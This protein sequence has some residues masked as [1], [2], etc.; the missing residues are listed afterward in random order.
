VILS[1]TASDGTAGLRAIK[2]ENGITIA[3]DPASAKF[4][5]MPRNAIAA[6]CVDLVLPP[7]RIAAELVRIAHHPF[8]AMLP[9][10]GVEAL[11]AK[12]EDWPRLFRLLRTA[13]TDFSLYKKSMIARRLGRRMAVHKIESLTEYLK[14]LEENSAELDILFQDI[15]IHVTSFFRDPEVFTALRD[16]IFPKILADRGPGEPVRIWV[17]G[18]STGEEVYSIAICLLEYLGDRSST[19]R[20]QIFASDINELALERARAGIYPEEQ[21]EGVSEERR[22]RFFTRVNGNYVVNQNIRELCVFARHDLTRDPPFS[23][24]DLL[25]CRNVLIYFEPTLQKRVLVSFHYALRPTGLLML[26]KTESI[27]T[28]ANLFAATDR[29]HKVLTRSP[30]PGEPLELAHATFERLAPY[31]RAKTE[32]PPYLDLEKEADRLVWERYAHAGIIVNNELQILHFRGQTAP[33]L[34]PVPGRASLNL[35]KM[36]REDLQM[37]LRAAFREARK[38]GGRVRREGIQ[39]THDQQLRLVNIEVCPLPGSTGAGRCFLVLIDDITPGGEQA[40]RPVPRRRGKRVFGEEVVRLEKELERMREHLQTVIHEQEYTNEELKTAN[41]EALSSMEELQSTN[42]EL[43]TAKEE[44]QS[45]NEE[46]VTLNE[47]L[48]NRNLELTHLSDDL[49]NVI[50]GV[51][52]PIVILDGERRIRRFTPPAE[53]LLGILPADVGRPIENLRIGVNVPDFKDLLSSILAKAGEVGREVQ[54]ENGHWYW[55]QIRPFRTGEQKIE[56]ALIALFDI[57]ELKQHQEALHNERNFVAAILDAAKD[58]LVIVLDH[59]GRIVQFNRV[60]QQL[61]GYSADEVKGRRPWDFLVLPEEAAAAEKTFQE[62]LGGRANQSERVWITKDGGRRLIDWSN[63]PATIDASVGGVIASGVDR[64]ARAEAHQRAEESEATVRALMEASS[65]A[66]L[67]ADRQGRIVLANATAEK[68]FGHGR[69]ELLGQPVEKLIPERFRERH[70]EHMAKWFSQPRN[71]QMGA[72]LELAGL[73]KDGSE[74]PVEVA[75]SYIESENGF[76]G[77]SFV[78]DIT[79]R[80]QNERALLDYQA[81]LQELSAKLMAIQESENRELARELHDVFSQ[82]LAALGIEIATVRGSPK[83]VTKRLAE[84]GSKIGR[85]AEQMHAAARRLHPQILHEL[86]LKAALEEECYGFSAETGIPATC[87]GEEL[88]VS[89]PADVA[90][91]LYRLAQEALL[92]IRKHAGAA[93]VHLELHREPEG[94]ALQIVDTGEGFDLREARK[95]G[96]LGLVSMEERVRLVDG[97][98]QIRSQPGS[99]TSVEVFVPL[100]K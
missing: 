38:S 59:E 71:R 79:E 42:E 35:S 96:G 31:D 30:A 5:G 73:R 81:R 100:K 85:L 68:M 25:S 4:D 98:V 90:L 23:K 99:G 20:I 40:S 82:E 1:G 45:S 12:E 9:S 28:F 27:S 14:L 70:A 36:V 97:R 93:T 55:L 21:L 44:L 32:A 65:Q 13:G 53:K 54:T 76:L 29:K 11:P 49:S 60:C 78:V 22:H 86:G 92:N 94:I 88:P 41:E 8:V 95:K 57:H 47:Q 10:K 6:G 51:D 15:L 16:Q 63:S 34:Q 46:L 67:A 77:V 7:G 17:P 64:T 69:D 91:C 75:L 43:E 18:C 84:I 3:Q 72:G 56:G 87:I 83:A 74:F 37:E 48:Q 33:Y 89:L 26:G 2:A 24:L 80:K 19:T 62:V 58:L 66:I 52:I 50:S 61:T 39:L